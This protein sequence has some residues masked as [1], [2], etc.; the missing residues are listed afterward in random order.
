MSRKEAIMACATRLFAEKGFVGT[1]TVEIAEA[2]GVAH[3]TLF[4]HFKNKQGIIYEI[5]Q[6]NGRKYVEELYAA[7]AVQCAGI[8]KINAIIAFQDTYSKRNKQQLLIFFRD[9]PGP[10]N[11]GSPVAELI[12]SIHQQVLDLIRH[13]LQT[14]I[15][16]GTVETDDIEKTTCLINSMI[17]GITHMDLMGPVPMPAL[18]ESAIAFCRRALTPGQGKIS[19]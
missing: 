8:E 19:V 16:D 10:L 15:A 3:G 5:F 13:S 2:A 17:F 12:R 7:A 1:S 11:T 9:F 14:G 18:T 4:Y 6:T